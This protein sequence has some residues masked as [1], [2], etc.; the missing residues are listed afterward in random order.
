[1]PHIL[2]RAQPVELLLPNLLDFFLHL[3]SVLGDEKP[4]KTPRG[5]LESSTVVCYINIVICLCGWTL[6]FSICLAQNVRFLRLPFIAGK[7]PIFF[8][9]FCGLDPHCLQVK[10][11]PT[12]V[13]PKVSL[14]LVHRQK[15]KKTSLNNQKTIH[16]Q[17]YQYNTMIYVL[18]ILIPCVWYSAMHV[19]SHGFVAS[20]CGCIESIAS[21]SPPFHIIN[22]LVLT[23]PKLAYSR[24]RS[25]NQK[26]LMHVPSNHPSVYSNMAEKSPN[27]NWVKSLN[28]GFLPTMELTRAPS[29]SES[30][31]QRFPWTSTDPI[32]CSLAAP[33]PP[34]HLRTRLANGAHMGKNATVN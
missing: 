6:V 17:P 30:T 3:L 8:I 7:I 20:H 2:R 28:W 29:P 11:Q 33:A 16:A 15:P 24:G 21:I 22:L 5:A 23:H 25:W 4:E 32:A 1:M 26:I 13:E 18:L 31:L 27:K 9:M 34:N 10:M 14:D 12:G 19:W